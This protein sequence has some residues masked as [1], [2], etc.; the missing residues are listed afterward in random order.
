[1]SSSD[2]ASAA[3][4]LDLPDLQGREIVVVTENA[5]PPRQFPDAAGNAIGW[6]YDAMAEIAKAAERDGVHENISSDAMVPAV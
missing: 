3:A 4:A 2:P 5:Y 6:E 1:M